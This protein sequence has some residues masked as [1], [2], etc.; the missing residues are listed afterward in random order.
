MRCTQNVIAY[1]N[2]V[3]SLKKEEKF[4]P[5]DYWLAMIISFLSSKYHHIHQMITFFCMD[6]WCL[7]FH[8]CMQIISFIILQRT[9]V[10]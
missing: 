4:E 9:F 10:N 2:I 8:S 1:I 6:G 3:C 5:K 7:F